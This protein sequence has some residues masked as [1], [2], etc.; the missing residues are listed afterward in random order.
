MN[1]FGRYARYYDII[2]SD[3]DYAAEVRAVA[4][5]LRATLGPGPR[6]VL[7]AGCGTGSHAALL[8]AL[9][10]DVTGVD[11]SPEML[12]VARDKV[13]DRVRLAPGDVR[14]L[15]L[16]EEFDAVVC[17]FAVVSYQL[18]DEDV[19]AALRSFHRHLHVGGLVVFD[20]WYAPAVLS[21]GPLPKVKTARRGSCRVERHASP[22]RLDP[23][24]RLNRTRYR[25]T[26]HDGDTLLEEFEEVHDVR[27]FTIEELNVMLE[28]C[29]F[30]V[31]RVFSG[32]TDQRDPDE[33]TWTAAIAARR[34]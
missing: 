11:R 1:E 23:D 29:R 22:E 19:R 4:E 20:F 10:H 3:K 2:Y 8:A 34:R 25:V 7:D 12:A 32:W 24:A 33:T 17:L 18:S 27:F 13:N 5:L 31:V 15:E 26:V 28:Q 30:D 6:R 9:G 21:I 16:G 14:H